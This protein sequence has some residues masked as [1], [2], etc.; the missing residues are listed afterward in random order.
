[1]IGERIYQAR[2][3]A[4]LSLRDL[5]EQVGVTAM[6]ISKYERNE[7][8]P[9]SKVLLGL[10]KSLGVRVEYFFRQVSV[11]LENVAHHQH[12]KLPAKEQAKVFADVKEQ[13]ERWIELEEFIPNPW[14]IPFE[15]PKELPKTI[16]SYDEIES[17]ADLMREQWKLGLN[18]IA[19]LVDTLE[20]KGIN[21]FITQYD[22]HKHFNGLS[23]IVNGNPVIVVGK[24]WPG[25]RQRFTLAHELGHLVLNDRLHKNLDEE[26][27]CHRFAG[28]F[29]VPQAKVITNL[30]NKRSWLEPQELM[31]LKHEYGLSMAGW[32]YRARDLGILPQQHFGKLW[33]YFNKHGWKEIEPNPQYPKEQ[34]HMFEQLVYHAL[35]EDLIGE[36]KAAELLGM[37][38][39]ALHAYRNMECPERV[40]NQ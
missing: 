1:M 17:V 13:L 4:G 26:L 6:A 28:A 24:H 3:A 11:A 9:S 27:A 18:P 10:S 15:L 25:D 19:D 20:A 8:T 23:A 29:L 37:S 14:S 36:A 5:A 30:G 22:G 32:L 40:I 39:T 12:E 7:S 31:I 21:V 16:K 34:T 35:A 2:K 33:S 38:V